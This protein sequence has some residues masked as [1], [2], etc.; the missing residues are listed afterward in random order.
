MSYLN[1]PRSFC[2]ESDGSPVFD[3]NATVLG[4]VPSSGIYTIN[5]PLLCSKLSVT[6]TAILKMSN[7]TDYSHFFCARH[8]YVEAGAKVVWPGNGAV[9][10]TAGAAITAGGS[11]FC[12]AGGGGNG[13]SNAPGSG[14][15]GPA[16]DAMPGNGGNGG[17][18]GGN[19]AGTGSNPSQLNAGQLALFRSLGFG[20]LFRVLNGN[21]IVAPN[22]NGGGGGGGGLNNNGTGT[23]GGG[24]GA[25]PNGACRVGIWEVYGTVGCPGGNGANGAVTGDG[26]AGGGGGGSGGSLWAEIDIIISKGTITVAGGPFGTG[27][28][29]GGAGQLGGNG[30]AVLLVG[31]RKS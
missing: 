22:G 9:G 23:G 7:G 1:T 24:G 26:V 30:L 16:G 2:D 28:G 31:G 19:G 3:G 15:T 8:L 25:A 4:F 29:G 17:A 27:A 13:G 21:S 10:A 12:E 6:G 5:R 18:A 11:L 20:D 14:G